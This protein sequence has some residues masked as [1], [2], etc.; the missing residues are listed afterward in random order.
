[1]ASIWNANLTN[2]EIER[3]AY[4]YGKAHL[5]CC[6]ADLEDQDDLETRHAEEL[7]AAIESAFK[8]GKQE[9]M[10]IDTADEIDRLEAEVE[11][12][13]A[14]HKRCRENLVAVYDWLRVGENHNTLAKRKAYADKV[15]QALNTTPRY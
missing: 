5:A 14:S 4:L 1:M 10:G 8:E 3:Y 13:K 12:L 2:S 15:R 9:G 11:K 7:E 6:A